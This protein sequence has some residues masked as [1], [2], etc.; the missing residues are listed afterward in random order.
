MSV[1]RRLWGGCAT[2]KKEMDSPRKKAGEWKT[3]QLVQECGSH[4]SPARVASCAA[5]ADGPP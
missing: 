5:V 4:E 3:V 2:A 1:E